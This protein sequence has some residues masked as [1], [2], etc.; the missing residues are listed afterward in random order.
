MGRWLA[1]RDRSRAIVG[2]DACLRIALPSRLTPRSSST[3]R[4]RSTKTDEELTERSMSR[5]VGDDVEVTAVDRKV[6]GES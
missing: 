1:P 2:G 5:T 4:S 3:G 6:A